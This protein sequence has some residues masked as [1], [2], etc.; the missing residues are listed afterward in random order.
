MTKKEKVL[1]ILDLLDK[2]Y[3]DAPCCLNYTQPYELLIAVRLSAQCTDA[4]VNLITPHLFNRYKTLEELAAADPLDVMEIVKSCGFYKVKGQ[5][6]V[7]MCKKLISDFGGK[8]PDNI[9]DLLTLP[10][11]GRKSA[12]LI[13]GDIYGKPAIVAD[14]HC[15]RI[16]NLLGLCDSKDPLKV[17]MTLKKIVPPMRGSTM[18]HQLVWFG[19]EVCIARRPKCDICELSLFCNYFVKTG[20]VG[21][22][23]KRK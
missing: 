10:G 7:D 13:V 5:N 12:N 1:N 18:C 19:R 14:T 16:T 4:R 3:G 9:D 17:E 15:I 20:G 21:E 22:K 23:K 8:V 11:I 6:I 2:R